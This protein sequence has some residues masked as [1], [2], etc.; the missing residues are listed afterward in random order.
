MKQKLLVICLWAIMAQA[1]AQPLTQF[2]SHPIASH[3]AATADGTRIAW[4]VNHLGMRNIYFQENGGP[5]VALTRYAADD[6]QELSDLVF[7]PDG[8]HL[9]FVR[10]G[11]PNRVGQLPNPASLAEGVEQAI[12]AVEVKAGSAPRKIAK[13]QRPVFLSDGKKIIFQV[14]GQIHTVVWGEGEVPW[15]LFQARGSNQMAGLSPDGKQLAFV[16]NRGD[17]SFVGVYR[18]DTHTVRWM[19]PEVGRDQHPVWSADGTQLAFIRQPGLKA[20]ELVNILGGTPFSIWVADVASAAARKVWQSP[21][22]DGGFSQTY[23]SPALSWSKAGRLLFFSEHTG[24]MHVF[25][26]NPDGSDVKDLTPGDG[27][28]ES[29]SL[30]ADGRTV[31]FDGNRTD[32]D[33]RHIW[34]NDVRGG[35]PVAVTQGLHIE[36]YPQ[37]VGNQLYAFQSGANFSKTLIRIRESEKAVEKIQP[38]LPVD[39]NAAAFVTPQQ[40]ILKAA[41]GTAVHA[42]LFMKPGAKSKMPGIVFMHG[43]PIRQM[44][45]GFHYSD[46]YINTYAFN[47][48][49][50][51]QGY[52]VISV[53]FRCGIG[54]GK[55]FR[56]VANSGPRG[57]S[58][59]Q[60]VVAAA[61]YLQA[62]PDVNADKIGL[63]GGSYGGYLTAMGLAR[64]PEIFKA[65]VD[66]HGVHD[67]AFRAREFSPGGGWG[68]TQ[69][70]MA[71]AYQSSPISDLSKW[72]APVLIVHGDDDRNVLFQQSTDL[73]EKLRDRQV[74]VELLILPDEVHG[75]LR[76]DSWKQ[77]FERAKQFFDVHLK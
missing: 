12:W 25:S 6:G 62:L 69:D 55:D 58:E 32:I 67:W 30:T 77:V 38:P 47:Q 71:V 74:P 56:R 39:F 14:G 76:Y 40:V 53:N 22:D 19:A 8:T 59:Y 34:K 52:A 61:K 11:A 29:F 57:A 26:M 20:G 70:L 73:A 50:A 36:M 16:S 41:D 31:Y 46:Y 13:G 75:F 9:L 64:S 54:Y 27:E 17:H 24:W 21:A 72:K 18:F 49:L 1:V 68:I 60:D 43:G 28:V 35:N 48:Y 4:V 42:Q 23:P 15:P 44:L 10:G 45:L 66:L 7:A 63:W 33:R 3:F 2:L 65:G 51:S 37:S 5:V